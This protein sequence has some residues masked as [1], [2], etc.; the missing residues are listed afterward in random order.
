MNLD[1]KIDFDDLQIREIGSWPLAL[2]IVILFAVVLA[3]LLLFNNLLVSS[4]LSDINN[5]QSTIHKLEQDYVVKNNIAAN[6]DEYRA[7]MQQIQA[8]YDTAINEIPASA[9]IASLITQISNLEGLKYELIKP[10]TSSSKDNLL[11][12]LPINLRVVGTYHGFGRFLSR[13]AG[14]KRILT[15]HDFTIVP[16]NDAKL[17]KANESYGMLVFEV[18]IKAYW[19]AG[20]TNNA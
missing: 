3:S 7:Q 16:L 11:M 2:R 5:Q 9:K 19:L 4:S 15:V 6:L 12:E 13:L 1:F 18:Q 10:G 17:L 20:E 8:I 14:L